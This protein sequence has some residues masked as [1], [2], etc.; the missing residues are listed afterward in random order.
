MFGQA[1]LIH[2]TSRSPWT[3]AVSIREDLANLSSTN[4]K[5]LGCIR[6]NLWIHW[7][8]L[9]SERYKQ[10]YMGARW[11][12]ISLR[13]FHLRYQVEHETINSV[14]TGAHV[15]FYL[16]HKHTNDHF[17]TT[18]RRF[19]SYFRRSPKILQKL[20]E[21]R[22]IVSKMFWKFP[23]RFPKTTEDFRRKNDD[24]SI[25]QEHI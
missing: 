15:L 18:F 23:K 12:G 25:I 6:Q 3:V 16:L 24:V 9:V 20:L 7:M 14:S 8:P 13:V 1:N 11:Y 17:F 2:P 22:R 5:S 21:D 10:K 4:L 19:P